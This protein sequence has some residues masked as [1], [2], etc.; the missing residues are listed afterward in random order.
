M[1]K[2]C[3][4]NLLVILLFGCSDNE[5]SKNVEAETASSGTIRISVDESFQPVMMEQIKVFESSFPKA[6]IIAEYKSEA[7]CFRDLQNDSTRMVIVSR[8]LTDEETKTYNNKIKFSPIYAELAYDAI[9]IVVNNTN[10]DSV[11]TVNE[12][13]AMLTGKSSKK[14]NVVVDGKNATSTVR[15]LIDSLLKGGT[16]G[17]NVTAVKNSDDVVNFVAN[18]PNYIG[19]VGIS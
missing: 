19:F 11:F 1:M 12:L 9:A 17:S 16:L 8:G 14:Y 15:F 5:A 7:D 2:S 13:K 3:F 18:N 10:A 6:K 4:V